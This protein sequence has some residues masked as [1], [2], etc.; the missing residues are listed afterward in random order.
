MMPQN[1]SG[2]QQTGKIAVRNNIAVA[3]GAD[4]MIEK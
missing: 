2:R 1:T 3:D 4:G